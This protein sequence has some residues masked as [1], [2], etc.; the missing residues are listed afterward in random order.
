MSGIDGL[1]QKQ[2]PSYIEQSGNDSVNNL[3]KMNYDAPN[4]PEEP[5]DKKDV[6]RFAPDAPKNN[7]DM[8]ALQGMVASMSPGAMI[9]ALLVQEA[10]EQN[11]QNVEELMTRGTAVQEKMLKQAEHIEDGAYKQ[12][13]FAIT[14]AVVSAA[15][16]VVGTAVG[17]RGTG[18]AL[19][20]NQMKGQAIS[21]IGGNLGSILNTLGTYYNTLEQAKIK[22]LDAS[23]EMDHTAME[24][25][26]SSMQAQ[27][28]LIHQSIE[29]INTMQASRNQALNRILG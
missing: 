3:G 26:K 20:V 1:G 24:L 10:A 16:S 25:L 29:F 5:N 2:T 8:S 28:D 23:I 19:K 7:V 27:R 6:R 18:D 11:Q 14:G 9:A 13:C 17:V 12:M 21:Q 22:K 15:G 4:L